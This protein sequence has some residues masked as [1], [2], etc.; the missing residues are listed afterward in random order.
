MLHSNDPTAVRVLQHER[1]SLN[2]GFEDWMTATRA[3]VPQAGIETNDDGRATIN[4]IIGGCRK[5]VTLRC[6]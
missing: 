2:D 4:G 3:A 5:S 6:A 1:Q